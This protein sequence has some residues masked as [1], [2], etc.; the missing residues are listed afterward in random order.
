M[1]LLFRNQ[2]VVVMALMERKLEDT[3]VWKFLVLKWIQ[4][5]WPS[6]K[7]FA[8]VEEAKAFINQQMELLSQPFAVSKS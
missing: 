5:T 8:S 4:Q 3:T 1:L 7:R 6:L 2:A